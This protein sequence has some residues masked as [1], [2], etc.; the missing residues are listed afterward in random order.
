MPGLRAR[1]D[2]QRAAFQKRL[3]GYDERLDALRRLEQSLLKHKT[4][5]IDAISQDF[6]V[7]AAE[8][9]LTL[10]LFPVL[11]EIR[12][13]IRHLRGWM[14]P[15]RA[16]VSWQFWP[17]RARVI[18]RPLGVVGIISPWNYPLFL[19]LGPLVGALAAGN[20]AMLKLSEFAPA[21]SELTES[22]LAELFSPSYVTV[23][24]GGPEAAVEFSNLP[25]DHLLFTGSTRVGKQVMS[26]ASEHLT[27]VT[28][29]LGGK[30][31][32]VVHASYSLRR[33]AVRL[34]MGK[35]YNAGQTCVAPDYLLLPREHH[36]RFCREFRK[37]VEGLYPRLVDTRDYTRIINERHYLRLTALVDDARQKGAEC[38]QINPAKEECSSANR[39]FP[40]TLLW[41][42][43]DSMQATQEEIFGPILPVVWYRELDEAIA[44]LNAR[45]HP[46][47]LY[48]FDGSG[49]R[50]RKVLRETA[51]GGVTIN[52]CIFHVG[53]SNL[54]FGGVGP[55]GMGR[56]HGFHGFE[57]FSH[58]Q[59]VFIQAQWSPLS[60]LRPPFGQRARWI[61]RFLVGA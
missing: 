32:A 53:Q 37:A 44:Y 1:F 46:L 2:A 14:E 34:A 56:Y 12:H 19:S 51:A 24:R 22:I 55:S 17:G 6:G 39:V 58:T 21:T 27:P 3:P 47:A 9:T 15:S 8:E 18:Y 54:P 29:E 60:L 5:I 45:P 36:D 61:L 57:A 49:P 31:P 23:E 48:Y 13:A 7:R 25:F 41:N 28:L 38:L 20:H 52:D 10:E 40:P 30:S 4:Q 35:L 59:G 11:N 50:V 43:N 33:A 16:P 26:A 42:M